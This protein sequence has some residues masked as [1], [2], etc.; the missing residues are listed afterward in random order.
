MN[1]QQVHEN[2]LTACR[3]LRKIDE[4]QSFK[5]V[6]STPDL[7]AWAAYL[8]QNRS[9]FPNTCATQEEQYGLL[10]TCKVYGVQIAEAE[11]PPMKYHWQPMETAPT[12][13]GAERR[14]DPNF[15]DPGPVLMAF[16][17]GEIDVVYH[18]IYWV[19]QGKSGWVC[20]SAGEIVESHYK[21]PVAWMPLPPHP[22]K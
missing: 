4:S 2:I 5:V 3:A 13:G 8:F 18:D 6:V 11:T 21:K 19:Y 14:D 12:S 17:G 9:D 7:K 1:G 10:K 22:S 15:R 16:E 20:N